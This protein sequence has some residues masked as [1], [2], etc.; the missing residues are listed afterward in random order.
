MNIDQ[1]MPVSLN[2]FIRLQFRFICFEVCRNES[3]ED[4]IVSAMDGT[5]VK[6]LYYTDQS[7]SYQV[8]RIV[9]ILGAGATPREYR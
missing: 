8:Q 1:T 2:V 9:P 7:G 4:L 6:I 3:I 5:R